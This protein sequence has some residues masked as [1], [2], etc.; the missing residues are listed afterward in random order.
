MGFGKYRASREV[1]TAIFR[2]LAVAHGNNGQHLNPRVKSCL[3][4]LRTFYVQT[5][6]A[7]NLNNPRFDS[8]ERHN[9][10][11]YL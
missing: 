9:K 8:T 10:L 11:I 3:E 4:L 1:I 7:L 5:K 2:I 6:N